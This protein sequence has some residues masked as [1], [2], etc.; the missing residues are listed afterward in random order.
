MYNMC[1]ICKNKDVPMEN[2][3][4]DDETKWEK[5]VTKRE[6][7]EKKRGEEKVQVPV[8]ITSKVTVNGTI[9]D[10]VNE[11][12]S[13]MKMFKKHAFNIRIQNKATKSIKQNMKENEAVVHAD[14]SENFACKFS[15]EI[16]SFHFGGSRQQVTLH[17]G[18]LYISGAKPV[19]FATVSPSRDHGPPAIWAHLRPILDYLK[20]TYPRVTTVHFFKDGT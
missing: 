16:Q 5:W 18:I 4:K 2:F 20:K 19:P 10:L 3:N 6:M 11:F 8:Q 13:E 15:E 12:Q 17:T 9:G 1:D 7:K 14:F